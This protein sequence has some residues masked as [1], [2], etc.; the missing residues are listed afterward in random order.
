VENKG[1]MVK[2]HGGKKTLAEIYREKALRKQ[3][4]G[5]GNIKPAT[6]VLVKKAP[7]PEKFPHP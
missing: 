5:D 1:V 7:Q 3:E 4:K 2:E 6:G